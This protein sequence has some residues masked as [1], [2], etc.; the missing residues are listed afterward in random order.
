V[1]QISPLAEPAQ[2]PQGIPGAESQQQK[3]EAGKNGLGMFAKILSGLLGKTA[4][5]ETAGAVPFTETVAPGEL[6]PVSPHDGIHALA[7]GFAETADMEWM[8][9]SGETDLSGA[10]FS[11]P[12]KNVSLTAGLLA[13]QP[14]EYT[15]K[16]GGNGEQALLA[17]K[18]PA[19][20][21]LKTNP[22]TAYPQSGQVFTETACGDTVTD[23]NLTAATVAAQTPE[24]TEKPRNAGENARANTGPA[25]AAAGE[26]TRKGLLGQTEVGKTPAEGYGGNKPEEI[27]VSDRRRGADVR[28][29]RGANTRTESTYNANT[30]ETRPFTEGASREVVLEVRMPTQNGGS[31]ATTTWESR[32]TQASG[33]VLENM[34]A[35]ELHQNL[36]G[37]IVRQA[38]I[39]LREGN[40]GT[41]RLAL[42]PESLGNVKIHLEMAENKITG[43]IV[44]ESEEALRAFE[45]E[46]ASLEK[47][48]RDAGFEGAELSMSLSDRGG[49]QPWQETEDGRFLPARL[50]ASRY[51]EAAEMTDALPALSQ[52]WH[53]TRTV[54]LLA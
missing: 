41:I 17:E 15:E 16:T 23:K 39:I 9:K 4:G 13:A 14:G 28:D 5:T 6:S 25:K 50:A 43:H 35:R 38:S 31:A 1:I 20:D 12:E 10:L 8:A 48:F 32:P 21:S 42:R 11:G 22:K 33:Q 29:I 45:R 53:G 36:N 19:G 2:A 7:A 44:V 52:Y 30:G 46:I 27:R 49:E 3:S 34:L 24:S 54:D 47:E 37:D 18:S 51:D 40:D 26:G